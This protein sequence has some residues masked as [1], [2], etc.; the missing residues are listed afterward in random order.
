MKETKT[1]SPPR[2]KVPAQKASKVA[3][4]NESDYTYTEYT[5]EECAEE[6]Q[7]VELDEDE[8]SD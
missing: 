1:K 6:R 2:S 8:D 5:V 4:G 3:D 7:D